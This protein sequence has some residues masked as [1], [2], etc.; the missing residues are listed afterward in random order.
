MT[1]GAKVD[2]DKWQGRRIA[3]EEIQPRFLIAGMLR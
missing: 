2:I 3:E 1:R